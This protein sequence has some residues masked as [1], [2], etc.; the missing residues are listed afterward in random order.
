MA[1]SR[2]RV[3]DLPTRLFHGL[4][5][6]LVL[7]QYGT[8]QWGWLDMEWHMRLG[9]ALLALLL[10]RLVWGVIGSDSSRFA[11]FVRSPWAAVRFLRAS[12]VDRERRTLGHNPLGGWSVLFMLT[13]LLVQA[14]SGLFS[15]DDIFTFGPLSGRVSGATVEWMTRVHLWNRWVLLALIVLHIAAVLVHL[16]AKR[17]NLITPMITG[18]KFV[19]GSVAGPVMR[20]SWWALALLILAALAV[21]ALLAWGSAAPY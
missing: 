4:L 17:D 15:S 3:W 7:L 19:R 2:V 21:W 16:I 6:L 5:V 12:V 18:D 11:R 14:V 20:S 13:S 8:A 10:F 1:R 9:Y